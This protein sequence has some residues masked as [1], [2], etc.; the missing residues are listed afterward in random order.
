[1]ENKLVLNLDKLNFKEKDFIDFFKNQSPEK[2]IGKIK[3]IA[4][5]FGVGISF[6]YTL[7]KKINVESFKE[8]IYLVNQQ[9]VLLKDGINSIIN[10]NE[11]DKIGFLFKIFFESCFTNSKLLKEQ[12]EKIKK[13]IVDMSKYP[14]INGVGFGHSYIAL[15]DFYAFYK[16]VNNKFKIFNNLN[17]S[18]NDGIR[19]LFIIY[20]LRSKNTRLSNVIKKIKKDSQAKIVLFTSNNDTYVANAVDDVIMVNNI[21]REQDAELKNNLFSPL[22]VWGFVNS[23]F[24]TFIFNYEKEKLMKVSAFKMENES[25]ERNSYF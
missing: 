7:L 10:S 17:F 22:I 6:I 23:I 14:I 3:D 12:E 18:I 2:Q 25:W 11:Q 16:N 1:M 4:S 13:L 8:F 9:P 19:K 5:T 21:M 15:E 20:S 24:K